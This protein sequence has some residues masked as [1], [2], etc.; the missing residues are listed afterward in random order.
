MVNV[1]SKSR[2]ARRAAWQELGVFGVLILLYVLLAVKEP[3]FRG[4][5][6]LRSVLTQIAMVAIVFVGMTGVIITA[7]IDLSVESQTRPSQRRGLAP[8]RGFGNL[9]SSG[10]HGS[11]NRGRGTAP[12][13]QDCSQRASIL[14]SGAPASFVAPLTSFSWAPSPGG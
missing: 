2:P 10:D 11:R 4:W 6:N 13:R 12:G 8:A 7:G 3:S 5:V 14:L 1:P 9:E